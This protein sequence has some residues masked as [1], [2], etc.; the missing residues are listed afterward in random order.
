M[1]AV[2]GGA[3]ARLHAELRGGTEDMM[4]FERVN[5]GFRRALLS[6]RDSA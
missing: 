3:Y 5:R 4:A 6:R 1:A 2:G